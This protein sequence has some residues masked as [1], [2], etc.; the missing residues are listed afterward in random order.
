MKKD[1]QP[2]N[3]LMAKID[4]P[5]QEA[6]D[7]LK[8]VLNPTIGMP[9]VTDWTA[10]LSFADKQKIV[11][12]CLPES[13]PEQIDKDLLL[14]WIGLVQLIESQNK[15][16]NKRINELSYLLKEAGLPF[17]LLKGQGNA[18][19]YPNPLRRS[20][21]DID[22]WIYAEED[23]VVDFVKSRIP[24]AE[25]SYKHIHFP[26]FEDVTIDIHTTP[27]KFYSSKYQDLLQMWIMENKEQQFIHYINLHGVDNKV[28]VPTRIFNVV[29]QMG[30]ML[31]HFFDEG[32]GLRQ[33]IDYYY[34]LKSLNG[35]KCEKSEVV[36]VFRNLGMSRFAGSVMWVENAILGLPFDK[37]MVEPYEKGGQKLIEDIIDGGN[38]GHYS[39]RYKG[40]K[41]YYG[42]GMAE[43]C[44]NIR[45]LTF[46]PRE[47]I[48]RLR[49]KMKMA[50]KHTI[51]KII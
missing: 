18:E 27:L 16:V 25:E 4:K 23:H 35:I 37:C 50:A 42:R 7:W 6:L 40:R 39:E 22:V 36:D 14:Q 47:D 41:S 13:C 43:A 15:L 32:V 49:S 5:T 34:V 33:M 10:L 1:T 3:R 46:A 12:V 28:S 20:P 11:G 26:I 9:T 30:H 38:F 31:I 24:E 48:A 19:L 21:G 44:R 45:L 29:Y 2:E 8:Y 17:C 51:K